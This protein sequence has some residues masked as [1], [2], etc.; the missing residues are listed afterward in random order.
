MTLT[1]ELDLDILPLDLHAK[2]QVRMSVCSTTR[3]VTHTQTDRQTDD[4]KSITPVADTGCKK[5]TKALYIYYFLST[6]SLVR[7]I[8]LSMAST[9]GIV[10]AAVCC[11]SLL[12]YQHASKVNAAPVGCLSGGCEDTVGQLPI[13]QVS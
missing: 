8:G 5:G 4:V 2:I 6:L 11:M 3:V 9:T 1:F 13:D 10:M 7:L 12:L